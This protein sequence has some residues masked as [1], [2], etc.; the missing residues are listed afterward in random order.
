MARKKGAISDV[1]KKQGHIGMVILRLFK[2]LYFMVLINT[3]MSVV[4][5]VDYKHYSNYDCL[6][7]EF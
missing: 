4:I 7:S 5:L 3:L 1:T 6:F 2:M